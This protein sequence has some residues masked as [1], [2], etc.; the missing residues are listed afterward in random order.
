[1][2]LVGI[3]ARFCRNS[4]HTGRS[5]ASTSRISDARI[6]SGITPRIAAWSSSESRTPHAGSLLFVWWMWYLPSSPFLRFGKF[7]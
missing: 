5:S 6:A 4:F 7:R 2:S 3:G 1:M